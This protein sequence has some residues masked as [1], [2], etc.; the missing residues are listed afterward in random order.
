MSTVDQIKEKLSIEEVLSS[1][2]KLERAGKNFKARCPFHNEKTPSFM[3]SP[4]RG[5]YHCFGCSRGGDIFSFVE[6]FE[7]TDFKGAL[8]VLAERAGVPLKPINPK[9]KNEQDRLFDTLEEATEF[10]VQNLQKNKSAQEY[11]KERGLKEETITEWKLGFIPDEWRLLKNH[12]KERGYTEKELL[13][14][15]LIKKSTKGGELYD[16]FRG[17]IIFPIF[18]SASR[19]VG[20]SGRVFENDS[21]AKYLNSPDGPLFNK[22]KLLYGFEHAKTSIRTYSFCILVEGQM[23]VL[24]AQQ[25]GFTNTLGIQGTALTPH[26]TD[27]LNRF[28]ENVVIA[29]DADPAGLEST[30]KSALQGL[31]RGMDVKIAELPQGTD[32]AEILKEDSKM[33]KKI[34]KEATHIVEFLT[35]HIQNE[36]KDLRKQKLRIRR[37]VLPFIAHMDNKVDQAHFLSFVAR[38]TGIPESALKEEMGKVADLLTLPD[39]TATTVSDSTKSTVVSSKGTEERIIR[40]LVGLIRWQEQKESPTFDVERA[41]VE[42]EE[43]VGKEVYLFWNASAEEYIFEAEQL[44]GEDS[45]KGYLE[46]LHTLK[47]QLLRKKFSRAME[48]LKHAEMNNDSS[49]ALGLLQ[50]CKDLSQQIE[51]LRSTKF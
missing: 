8:K 11:L 27:I 24:L 30:K 2:I 1:Y 32:P 49:R 4:D 31:V 21:E 17:R 5:T 6:E 16:T 47:E 19:V 9:E 48:E 26:H 41:Q 29:L 23:D 44:Y 51:Q 42:I 37:E 20:F 50:E 43:L 40:V 22:S 25:A 18:D 39:Y 3:V 46:L 14:A 13:D 10:F 7:R 38:K 35:H 12:L 34:I 15:G 36:E 33:W 45:G 28:T